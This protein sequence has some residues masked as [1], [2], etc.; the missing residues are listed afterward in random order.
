VKRFDEGRLTVAMLTA[1]DFEETGADASHAEGI[2]DQVRTV[3]GTKVA[4]LIRDVD[5][6]HDGHG[7]R[8]VSLR[9]TDDDV[10]VSAIAHAFGGGG[11]RRAAA[12]SSE[13]EP[14]ALID[15]LRAR[16]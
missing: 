12:F 5:G 11:H 14:A 9:A 3:A 16:M 2:I 7:S 6:G 13:L 10:D 15:A 8:R 4:V 1:A